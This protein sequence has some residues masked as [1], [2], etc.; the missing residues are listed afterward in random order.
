MYSSFLNTTH[1]F[2]QIFTYLKL[3]FSPYQ[4]ILIACFLL[5]KKSIVPSIEIV[6]QNIGTG[7]TELS[8]C[9]KRF[10]EQSE[11]FATILTSVCNKQLI[12]WDTTIQ[13][14]KFYLTQLFP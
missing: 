4:L 14:L 9:F 6:V 13:F 7:E 1:L 3:R 10:F 11:Q 12:D 2:N 8:S 5:Q